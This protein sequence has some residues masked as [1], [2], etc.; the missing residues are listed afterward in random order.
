MRI[1]H[2][3][4]GAGRILPCT[5]GGEAITGQPST[6]ADAGQESRAIAPRSPRRARLSRRACLVIAAFCAL[7]DVGGLLLSRDSA[8]AADNVVLLAFGLAGVIALINALGPKSRKGR[9]ALVVGAIVGSFFLARRL[10]LPPIPPHRGDGRFEDLSWFAG[11]L[12]IPGYSITMPEFDLGTSRESDYRLANLT[13]I[14]QPCGV[15]LAIFDPK[16]ELFGETKGFEGKLRLELLDSH[17]NAVVDV[18]G[19]LGDFIW[20]GSDSRHGL[21]LL[22]KSFFRP[23]VHETYRLHLF[24]TPDPKLAGYKGFVYVESGGHL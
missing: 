8:N 16:L 13:N 9:I 23:N 11:P 14:G 2:S 4:K 7:I 21:Y 18:S 19:R 5:K 22:D 15:Y 10:L 12:P 1:D 3:Y 17:D 24:Y 6:V 20:W